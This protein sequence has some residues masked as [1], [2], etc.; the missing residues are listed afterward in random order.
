MNVEF[1]MANQYILD[2][3]K[4][5]KRGLKTKVEKGW[6]PTLAPIGYRNNKYREKGDARIIID[7]ER[8]DLVKR[9]WDMMLTGNYTPPKIAHI[10]NQEWGFIT[11]K[12]RPLAVSMLYKVLI[13][14]FYSGWFEYPKNS[15]NWY[16]GNHDPMVSRAEYD[17]VQIL[18]GRKGK[19]RIKKHE[20]PYTGLIRCGEC[21]AMVTAEQ[22]NQIVFSNCKC[23]FSSNNKIECPKC[24]MPID[25]M[26]NPLIRRYVYYHCTKRINPDC[27]QGS[28]EAA[29][30]EKQINQLLAHIHISEGFKNWAVEYLKE[31]H[32]EEIDSI[33]NVLACRRKAYDM[34]LQKLNNL[35]QLKISPSNSNGGLLS[36]KNT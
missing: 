20:F 19:P 13:S 21:G 1:G 10:A 16:K 6:L 27:S 24:K 31:K 15:G 4:N 2:L 9:M 35:F 18:L 36:T 34:C 33:E 17:K 26:N 29:E 23:K 28:I 22:K 30:L 12:Q 5:V 3:S 7:P 25:K 11:Q 32:K 14:P 8:F